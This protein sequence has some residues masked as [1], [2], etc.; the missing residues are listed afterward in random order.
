MSSQTKK[1]DKP[2]NI[3]DYCDVG[4]PLPFNLDLALYGEKVGRR[5]DAI[6]F[7]D[8]VKNWREQLPSN[9]KKLREAGFDEETLARFSAN[10]KSRIAWCI[11]IEDAMM[12]DDADFFGAIAALIKHKQEGKPKAHAPEFQV[13]NEFL[14]LLRANERPSKDGKRIVAEYPSKGR[15]RA[16]VEKMGSLVTNWPRMWKRLKLEWLPTEKSGPRKR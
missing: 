15:I 4:M 1:R 8:G 13:W 3:P 10:E 12:R 14:R 7:Y 6:K 9:L 5:R 2:S 16:A 11:Y